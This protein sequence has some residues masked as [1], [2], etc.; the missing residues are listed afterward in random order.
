MEQ[1]GIKFASNILRFDMF[2]SESETTQNVVKTEISKLSTGIEL[3]TDLSVMRLFVQKS[4]RSFPLTSGM[5]D[6]VA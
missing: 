1:T 3:P 4:N 6:F 2:F 5:H